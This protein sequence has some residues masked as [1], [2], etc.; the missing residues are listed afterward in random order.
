MDSQAV[1]AMQANQVDFVPVV[2]ADLRAFVEQLLNI[3]GEYEGLEGIAVYNPASV[4]GAGVKLALQ[5]LNGEEVETTE[6]NTVFLPEPPAYANDTPEGLADLEAINVP[7][8]DPLWPV[9]WEI[10]GWTDYTFDEMKAC[11]G[12]GE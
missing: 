8:L 7:E 1:S 9:S 4:G 6:G 12:P 10:P 5:V 2:G 11:K 3:S